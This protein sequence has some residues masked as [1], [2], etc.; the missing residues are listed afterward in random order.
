[1][2]DEAEG[3]YPAIFIDHAD[4][5]PSRRGDLLP[6]LGIRFDAALDPGTRLR[7]Y[8]CLIG[9]RSRLSKEKQVQHACS[10]DQTGFPGSCTLV[11]FGGKNVRRSRSTH[12]AA[13][14][15]SG[16]GMRVNGCP[17]LAPA[18]RQH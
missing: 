9:A 4:V 5:A 11:Q 3:R 12:I 2:L 17:E 16:W 10:L 7:R 6:A 18:I 14:N 8:I 13:A 1:M 15:K